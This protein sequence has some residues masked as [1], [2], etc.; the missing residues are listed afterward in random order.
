MNKR[1]TGVVQISLLMEMVKMGKSLKIKLNEKSYIVN[2]ND[3]TT[4]EEFMRSAPFETSLIVAGNH[5]YG[6]IPERLSIDKSKLTSNPHSGG[7]YYADHVQSVS[8]YYGDSG[9]IKPF[10]IVY[11]GDV[12]EDMPDL[13]GAR[14]RVDLRVEKSDE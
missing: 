7:V 4:A 9:S 13:R 5:C 11:I 1:V 10:E 8:I 2:L 3:S 6:P 12:Q 14:H